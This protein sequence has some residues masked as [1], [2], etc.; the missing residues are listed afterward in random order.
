[1]ATTIKHDVKDLALTPEGKRRIPVGR[2]PDAGA[3]GDPL[4]ASS[5]KQPLAATVSLACFLM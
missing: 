4:S 2:H 5:A 3:G 1:M